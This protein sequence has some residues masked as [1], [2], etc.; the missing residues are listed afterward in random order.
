MQLP[1]SGSIFQMKTAAECN[2]SMRL[3]PELKLDGGWVGSAC[4]APTGLEAGSRV[5]MKERCVCEDEVG[6][7][8]LSLAS[9]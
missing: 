6:S 7:D 8:G 4:C 9:M 2:I 3:N 1:T 5:P